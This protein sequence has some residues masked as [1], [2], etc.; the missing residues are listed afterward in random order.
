MIPLDIR[1]QKCQTNNNLKLERKTVR[2]RNY[3]TIF[4]RKISKPSSY[5]VNKMNFKFPNPIT[6]PSKYTMKEI[7]P[8]SKDNA[9]FDSPLA[10]EL[11]FL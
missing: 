7:F 4:Q 3:D 2:E 8:I 6:S 9:S 11:C 1:H 5:K 10:L